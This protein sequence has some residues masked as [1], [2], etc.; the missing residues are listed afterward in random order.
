MDVSKDGSTEGR[1]MDGWKK[2]GQKKGRINVWMMDG[3]KQG[4]KEV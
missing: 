4:R 2:E 1:M 3:L